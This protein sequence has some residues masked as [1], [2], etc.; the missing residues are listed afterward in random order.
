MDP[1]LRAYLRKKEAEACSSRLVADISYTSTK[2]EK[3]GVSVVADLVNDVYEVYLHVGMSVGNST[4]VTASLGVAENYEKVGDYGGPFVDAN[5][6]WIIGVDHCVDPREDYDSA[7]KATS[8]TIGL[9]PAESMMMPSA[10][11]GIDYYFPP[12]V[13]DLYS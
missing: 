11:V 8:L 10:S 7:V 4:G 13:I 12:I 1:Q 9:Y 2:G 5:A 6:S 3:A